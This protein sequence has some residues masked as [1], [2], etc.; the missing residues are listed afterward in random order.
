MMKKKI[1]I[2]FFLSAIV[3]VCLFCMK[4]YL[5]HEYKITLNKNFHRTDKDIFI[6]FHGIYGEDKDLEQISKV[7]TD[8]GYPVVNIQYPTT[9]ENIE[10]MTEKYISSIIEEHSKNLNRINFERKSRNEKEIKLN[11]IVHSMGSVLL[12]YYL[13]T[14]EV[15]NIGKVLF[16]SPPSHGSHLSDNFISD[17]L[18]YFIGPAVAQIK[19]D[20]NS[21]VNTLGE[22]DYQCYILTGDHSDNFIYSLIIPGNDDGMI[23]LTTARLQNCIIKTIE[24]TTHTTILKSEDTFKEI[25]NYFEIK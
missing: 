11:F 7:L 2:T 4:F 19:T 16:I 3:L 10:Q 25:E 12:R 8:K 15:S 20:K 17:S 23:P 22:P 21:F 1:A 9:E 14:H 24:N 6:V 5:T 13:K 18:L